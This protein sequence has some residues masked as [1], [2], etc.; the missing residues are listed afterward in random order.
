M[1][2]GNLVKPF[3]FSEAPSRRKSNPSHHRTVLAHGFQF[4]FTVPQILFPKFQRIFLLKRVWLVLRAKG[5]NVKLPYQ[6]IG[7]KLS[8]LGDVCQAAVDKGV[9]RWQDISAHIVGPAE[10]ISSSKSH[11]VHGECTL[12]R[13]YSIGIG[14]DFS[15]VNPICHMI[16]TASTAPAYPSLDTDDSVL[17]NVVVNTDVKVV[18]QHVDGIDVSLLR[19]QGPRAK[20]LP[21]CV[22]GQAMGHV[23]A[24]L[25]KGESVYECTEGFSRLEAEGALGGSATYIPIPGGIGKRHGSIEQTVYTVP[26]GILPTNVLAYSS[27]LTHMAKNSL[28]ELKAV[29]LGPLNGDTPTIGDAREL[30]HAVKSSLIPSLL[31]KEAQDACG[32]E[33][34]EVYFVPILMYYSNAA[35]DMSYNR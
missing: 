21:F 33:S 6:S 13:D 18:G 20:N 23:A 1:H 4:F 15:E 29:R 28:G 31:L 9:A 25:E 27:T 30:I 16:Y 26:H 35:F 17:L 14:S 32:E 19:A 2:E 8:Q 12:G 11:F 22:L 34:L 3:T 7:M 24:C 5:A 10:F